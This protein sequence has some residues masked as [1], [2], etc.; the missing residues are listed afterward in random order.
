MKN[1]YIIADSH[2][3]HQDIIDK[4]EFRPID[5]ARQICR[6]IKNNVPTESTLIHLWDVIFKKPYELKWYLASMWNM[7]KILVKGNHDNKS[8]H[9]Y[10]SMWFNLVVDEIKI[11]N[12]VFTHIPKTKLLKNEINCHWH[13]HRNSHTID[14][15]TNTPD[16][17]ILYSAE[18]ENYMPRRLDF[19][20]KRHQNRTTSQYY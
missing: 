19:L 9:F 2:F 5:Y 4:Y 10:H 16:N 1:I 12:I 20:I 13:L 14:E 18:K 8:N 17:Y 6:K 11:G 3:N 15:F 7:T